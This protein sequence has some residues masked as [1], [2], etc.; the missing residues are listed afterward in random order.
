MKFVVF[1][2]SA[3]RA[4]A[5]SP[6]I[7][8][9]CAVIQPDPR[10]S[11]GR[12]GSRF[13][14]GAARLA[15][16]EGDA[17]R[18]R[19]LADRPGR[20]RIFGVAASTSRPCRRTEGGFEPDFNLRSDRWIGESLVASAHD[21]CGGP[22]GAEALLQRHR[23]VLAEI[24]VLVEH[25]DLGRG[26]GGLQAVTW[27]RYAP[28][29]RI[30][31]CPRGTSPGIFGSVANRGRPAER[32]RVRHFLPL[33]VFSGSRGLVWRWSEGAGA[34]ARA[35]PDPSNQIAARL[36]PALGGE[37]GGRFEARR[38]LGPWVPFDA[39]PGRSNH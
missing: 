7:L 33:R 22:W 27:R 26:L 3:S 8:C 32:R 4:K 24:V 1:D 21:H 9:S 16:K 38:R 15:T 20:K 14:M 28:P 36:P 35:R 31:G 5:G 23:V 6:R 13:S 37:E 12:P 34:S 25:R 29:S 18:V 10:F 39:R 11:T 17:G 19:G 2:P 30:R